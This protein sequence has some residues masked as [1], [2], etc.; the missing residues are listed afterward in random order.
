MARGL[1]LMHRAS[2][3]TDAWLYLPDVLR[4]KSFADTV[5]CAHWELIEEDDGERDDGST[6]SGWWR[7]TPLGRLFILGEIK[8]PKYARIYDGRLLGFIGDPVSIQDALGAR[9]DYGA[10][11][12]GEA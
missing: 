5:K 12:R 9:F 4:D 3:D 8:V 6:R 7:V 10:L 2:P 11:M 1:I